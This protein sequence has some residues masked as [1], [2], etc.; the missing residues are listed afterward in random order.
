MADSADE[1]KKLHWREE[2]YRLIGILEETEYQTM[3]PPEWKTIDL[4]L[5][6]WFRWKMARRESQEKLDK[7]IRN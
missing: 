1:A 3:A 6:A 5:V 7:E 2:F 4:L